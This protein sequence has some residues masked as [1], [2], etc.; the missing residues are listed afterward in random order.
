LDNLVLLC[1]RHHRA[2]HED[3]FTVVRSLDGSVSFFR[4]DGQPLDV[5]PPSPRWADG[6]ANPLGPTVARIA[7][8]SL[9]T[10]P[11]TDTPPWDGTPFDVVWVIDVLRG[12]ETDVDAANTAELSEVSAET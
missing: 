10:H 4:P 12:R 9:A 7:D 2:V 11:L 3:G 1:R 8:P 5:A 6:Q